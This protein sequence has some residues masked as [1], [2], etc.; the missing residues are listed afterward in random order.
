MFYVYVIQ[1]ESGL[2]YIGQ[3][4]NLEN[5]L[6]QHN[7]GKSKYTK[8]CKAWRLVYQEEFS[9]R[10]AAIFREAELKTSKG[11]RFLK[12]LLTNQLGS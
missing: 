8:R 11:R 6:Q 5:R 9:T 4:E 3:T 2:H 1:S 10:K 7:E 12:N